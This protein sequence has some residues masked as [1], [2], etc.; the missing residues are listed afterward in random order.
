MRVSETVR[1]ESETVW[2]GNE[3]VRNRVEMVW[4]GGEMVLGELFIF[5]IFHERDFIK[6]SSPTLLLEKRRRVTIWVSIVNWINYEAIK[7]CFEHFC[8][9]HFYFFQVTEVIL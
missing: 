6:T 7:K 3:T 2:D 1:S 5:L 8:S 9:K 4:D